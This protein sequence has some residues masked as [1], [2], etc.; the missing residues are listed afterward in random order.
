MRNATNRSYEQIEGKIKT[1]LNGFATLAEIS[2]NPTN[3]VEI[4]EYCE[5]GTPYLRIGNINQLEINE[6][7]LAYVNPETA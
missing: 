7:S 5:N 6:K 2:P 3:G 4:R 1:H